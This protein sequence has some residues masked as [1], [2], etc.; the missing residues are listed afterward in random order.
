MKKILALLGSILIA[1]TA[2]ADT[3]SVGLMPVFTSSQAK[4]LCATFLGSSTISASLIPGTD[5]A[6]DI[7]DA[8]HAMRSIY[9]ETSLIPT[10]TTLPIIINADA[11]RL[12][13]VGGASDT[14]LSLTWGDAGTTAV[15]Q[16]TIAAST[17]DADDDSSLNLAGGGAV[18]GTR[19]A[20]I[21]LAGEEV[22]GG[23][24][25][26]MNTGTGDVVAITTAGTAVANIGASVGLAM[27]TS[28][29]TLALQE[30]TAGTKCM[31]TVTFNGTTAVTTA[32]TCAITGARIFLTPTSDPTGSTAAYC[33]AT[34]IV[35]ATSFDVDCDQANDGTAH[36]IIFHEAA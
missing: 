4:E 24:D 26:T 3:C 31:G 18:G 6:Y 10:D 21:I 11:Q 13:T 22:S 20:S 32:T 27:A 5:D 25:I 30:A 9:L 2:V 35:N 17:A 19:G 1:G 8:T 15:Q 16:L 36:W 29:N 28:G 33:W 14:A 23:G 12:L 7:G 34:N